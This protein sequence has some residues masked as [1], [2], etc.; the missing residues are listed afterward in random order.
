M[1]QSRDRDRDRDRRPTSFVWPSTV[2]HDLTVNSDGST[3][4]AAQ[5]NLEEIIKNIIQPSTSDEEEHIE[6]GS[7]SK[8]GNRIVKAPA[9]LFEIHKIISKYESTPSREDRDSRKILNLSPIQ[10]NPR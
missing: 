3:G 1:N 9:G 4:C 10:N 5:L 8:S 2:L 7:E 6:K